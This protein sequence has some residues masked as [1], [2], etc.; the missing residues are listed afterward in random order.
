MRVLVAI[1]LLLSCVATTPAYQFCWDASEHAT[2][3]RVYWSFADPPMWSVVEMSSTTETCMADPTPE[4]VPG[5]IIY[6]LVTAINEQGE[7]ETEHGPII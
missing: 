7:S 6:F 3:Y 4:P 1:I 5:E 2:A